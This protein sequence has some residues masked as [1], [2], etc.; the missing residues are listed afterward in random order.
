MRFRGFVG[1]SYV[2]QS[3]D[4]ADQ[5]CVNW[6]LEQIE[7]GDE[8]SQSVL[9]PTPGCADFATLTSDPIS[10][11]AAVRTSG[12][13]RCFAVSSN[14]LYEIFPD[15]SSKDRGRVESETETPA[16]FSANVDAGDEVFVTSGGR[17]YILTLSTNVLTQVMIGSDTV[18][19]TSHQGDF[20]DGFFLALNRDTSTLYLS[21][22]NDGAATWDATQYAQ[23]TA[24]IRLRS[25]I[26]PVPRRSPLPLFLEPS[27]RRG[28]R[29]QRLLPSLGI[30]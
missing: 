5:R 4:A 24:R 9:Y 28:L 23:R 8:P 14:T 10:S 21:E 30:R 19:I 11:I 25:G 3:I 17:G 29:P 12:V 18:P 13:D 16:T 22:L 7:V 20:L 6:Y 26:T 1:P 27:S 15:G 2:S